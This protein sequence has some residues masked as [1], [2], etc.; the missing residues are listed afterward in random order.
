MARYVGPVNKRMRFLG[1][2]V[3]RKPGKG[4]KMNYRGEL[5]YLSDLEGKISKFN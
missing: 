2:E 5:V 4:Q 3:P 1:L